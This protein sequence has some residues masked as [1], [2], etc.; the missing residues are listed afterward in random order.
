MES[1]DV[2]NIPVRR[3]SLHDLL[4]TLD[5]GVLVTPNLDHLVKL[6]SDR[7]F[8]D[9]YMDAE[10]I[11]CDSRILQL[12]SRMLRNP[13]PEAIPGSSFFTHFYLHHAADPDCR[14]FL[15]GARPG[16]ADEAMRRINDRVGRP[17][18]VGAHSPSFGFEKNPEENREITEIINRSGATVVLV[19][20]GAP[21]QEKWIAAHRSEMPGVRLWMALGATIDFEAGNI[22]RAPRWVQKICMEWFYR[23]L[24]EP[25]R[26]FR[27]Y[28]VDDIRFFYHFARQ[29]AGKYRNPFGQKNI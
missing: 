25:R 19:G 2:L 10:W 1:T 28:F 24:K 18:V 20:V 26:M 27:R 11:V 15:L 9:A 21:K 5:E 12:C 4:D 23:F 13:I 8:Y 6:Q 3:I 22:A 17:I 29:L 16:V 7:G 14:I